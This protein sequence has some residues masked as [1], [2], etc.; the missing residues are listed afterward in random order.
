MSS[1]LLR[2]LAP[3]SLFAVPFL[4]P[5]LVATSDA[6]GPAK[7]HHHR[8]HAKH[9]TH[10][11]S[12]GPA[13]GSAVAKAAA[14]QGIVIPAG[15]RHVMFGTSLGNNPAQTVKLFPN[16]RI[17]RVFENTPRAQLPGLPASYQIWLSF[18]TSPS[19][20]ASGRFNA[21]FAGLLKAWNASGRTVFWD[22]QHEADRQ[23]GF[24]SAQFRAGWAQL[25]SVERKYPSTR[26][27]SMSILTGILLAPNQPHGNPANWYVNA[28]VLGFDCYVPASVPRAMAYARSKG[29]PWAIPEF[30]AH[31]GDSGD[32]AYITMTINQFASY[33]PIGA[34]WFNNTAAANFSQ[35]LAKLP[36]TTAYLRALAAAG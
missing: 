18:N 23:R 8:Q 2:R 27:R 29:K 24:S 34:A 4:I 31:S 1:G 15:A 16:A 3:L 17:G 19:L 25:L 13:A 28:D 7:H 14:S 6:A 9:A 33:P 12:A 35:P 20:V 32:V 11:K 26:V 21:Q 5:L 36:R 30:G 22:W 10:P